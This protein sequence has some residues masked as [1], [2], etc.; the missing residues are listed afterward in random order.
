[1][2]GQALHDPEMPGQALHDPEM[3]GQALH[4][5]RCQDRHCMIRAFALGRADTC[6]SSRAPVD[7]DARRDARTGI[8]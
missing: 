5:P 7:G 1:M 8:A 3:P 2:P 4:D 6:P